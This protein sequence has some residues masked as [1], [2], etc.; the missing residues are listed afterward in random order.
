MTR[1]TFLFNTPKQLLFLLSFLLLYCAP[2]VQRVKKGLQPA[3][4]TTENLDNPIGID[5]RVPRLSWISTSRE[6]G[7]S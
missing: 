1:S 7:A 5:V 3:Q 6:R 4:L 2:P